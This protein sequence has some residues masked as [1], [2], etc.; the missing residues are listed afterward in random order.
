M[1]HSGSLCDKLLSQE[2]CRA[3]TVTTTSGLRNLYKLSRYT[4]L[5]GQVYRNNSDCVRHELGVVQWSFL[6]IYSEMLDVEIP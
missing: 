6:C 2:K 1:T 5:I 3:S 4:I